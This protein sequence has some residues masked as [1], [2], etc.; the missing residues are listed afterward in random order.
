MSFKNNQGRFNNFCVL[1]CVWHCTHLPYP[2]CVQRIRYADKDYVI[3]GMQSL[4]VPFLATC[5]GAWLSIR[6]GVSFSARDGN[7]IL[8]PSRVDGYQ[9]ASLGS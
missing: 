4:Q 9:N 2:R 5:R 3:S 6:R 7:N 1:Q 8:R